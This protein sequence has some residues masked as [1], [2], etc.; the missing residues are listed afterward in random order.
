MEKRFVGNLSTKS[1]YYDHVTLVLLNNLKN[2]IVSIPH[3]VA[4]AEMTPNLHLE[5]LLELK[6]IM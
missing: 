2:L 1:G 4:Y 3:I 5:A 6:M